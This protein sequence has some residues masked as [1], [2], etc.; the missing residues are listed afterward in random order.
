MDP[1]LAGK[2]RP[3]AL[4]SYLDYLGPRSGPSAFFF[5]TTP[6]EIKS[7]CQALDGTKGPGQ[8]D[9]SPAALR[10]AASELSAPLSRLV[11]TCLEAGHFLSKS[12]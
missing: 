10:F 12:G 3:P 7:L 2:V 11:N 1:D 4:G 6:A 5:P 8:D 9:V